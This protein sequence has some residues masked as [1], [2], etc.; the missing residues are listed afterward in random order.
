M[1][2][3]ELVFVSLVEIVTISLAEIVSI[4]LVKF[5]DITNKISV[6]VINIEPFWIH[7]QIIDSFGL[8][9]CFVSSLLLL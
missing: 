9:P 4:Q 1:S 8:K 7:F 2:L 3:A 6:D 5:V